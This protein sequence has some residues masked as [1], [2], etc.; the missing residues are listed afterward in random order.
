DPSVDRPSI[1]V[2]FFPT[3]RLTG[4]EQDRTARPPTS[5]VQAPHWPI[6][7]PYLVPVSPIVSRRTHSSGVSGSTS[8]PYCMLLTS[9]VKAIRFLPRDQ[10]HGLSR[11]LDWIRIFNA[12]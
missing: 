11:N 8:T 10:D 1:V 12:E 4:T 2:V 6:P 5:T 9:S 7:Q 3:A